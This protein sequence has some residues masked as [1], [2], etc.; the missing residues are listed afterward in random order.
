MLV[1]QGVIN[2]F[3][4]PTT[5]DN[6]FDAKK[7]QALGDCWQVIAQSLCKF[8]YAHFSSC[9]KCEELQSAGVSQSPKDR[10]GPRAQ[11]DIDQRFVRRR[12]RVTITRNGVT[13]CIAGNVVPSSV[14]LIF[15][16]R[17]ASFFRSSSFHG[18]LSHFRLTI[19]QLLS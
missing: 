18:S 13:G 1:R 14:D 16:L 12:M 11:I 15:A 17:W 7:F 5:S 10:C 3:P 8:R 19:K 2:V 4:L 6:L 9:E